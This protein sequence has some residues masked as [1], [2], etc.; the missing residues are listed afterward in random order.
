MKN[1]RISFTLLLSLITISFSAEAQF[2]KKIQNAA[3][4]GIENAIQQKV[5]EE[6]TKIT[7]KQLEKLFT[8]MYGT[9]ENGTASGIDMNQIMKGLGE[10]VDT[11]SSYDF[12]GHIVFELKSTDEKGK[13]ADPILM[14][15]Y[16]AKS[17]DITGMELIDPKNPK[18]ITALVFDKK[19]EAS[20][21][22]LDNK[23]EKSSFAYKLDLDGMDEA[24]DEEMAD[25]IEDM[26]FTLEKTGKTKDILG[27]ECEEY[28][29][30]NEDGEGYYW[31][32]EEPIGGYSSFW[33]SNSPL[34]SSKAQEKYADHF[35]NLP[36]GNFMELTYTSAD[37]GTMEMKV[38]EIN[39][40]AAKSFTMAEYP[41]IMAQAGQ[42]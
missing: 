1:L 39:D 17:S 3:N 24:L 36:K 40:S 35:S 20:I 5:E 28:H 34:M 4:R 21:V 8:D 23:G 41:N 7:Q 33:S 11:E 37:S 27:Y 30:K 26:D 13:V 22:F 6:A 25:Q 15:S 32:T 16:L 12:S 42:K 38:T 9:S 14:K 19:N 18:A 29:V 2:I 10:P 31:I